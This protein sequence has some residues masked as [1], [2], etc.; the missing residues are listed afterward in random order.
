MYV[1][2]T[3]MIEWPDGD[4][5][6]SDEAMDLINSFLQQDPLFRLGTGGSEDVKGHRFFQG[7]DWNGLLRQKADFIPQLEGEDDTSYFDGGLS[8]GAFH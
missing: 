3:V 5:A 6:L 4:D 2:H 7:V 1:L 8:R